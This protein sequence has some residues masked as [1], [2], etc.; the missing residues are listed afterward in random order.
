MERNI[1]DILERYNDRIDII[2]YIGGSGG[3]YAA[4]LI[5]Q[6]SDLY[7]DH[8]LEEYSKNAYNRWSFNSPLNRLFVR[9]SKLDLTDI[10]NFDLDFM[11]EFFEEGYSEGPHKKEAIIRSCYE[12]FE[13]DNQRMIVRCHGL[14]DY[15][16]NYFDKSNIVSIAPEN[17]AW[18]SY[19]ICNSFVKIQLEQY[20]GEERERMVIGKYN[21]SLDVGQTTLDRVKYL[22]FINRIDN[23]PL[24]GFVIIALVEPNKYGFSSHE[25]ILKMDPNYVN[26]LDF[27]L[28]L[29]KVKKYM[30]R[31]SLNFNNFKRQNADYY[32][33]GISI[34]VGELIYG[35]TIPE[36]FGI[37]SNNAPIFREKMLEWHKKNLEII[38]N[39]ELETG[40]LMLR[41][42]DI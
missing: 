39:F 32:N 42:H 19:I 40:F 29:D 35:N 24:Y 4:T 33:S 1:R 10:K 23:G 2:N 14:H 34:G 31:P 12:T 41:D 17:E 25:D 27:L 21:F 3:E 22:D 8:P 30:I 18:A 36:I 28:S 7:L 15:I 26:S 38:E 20:E 13:K 37:S 16:L 9:L 6:L 5:T 11:V